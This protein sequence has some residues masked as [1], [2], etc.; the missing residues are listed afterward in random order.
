MSAC[1]QAAAC[2]EGVA[3]T[4][5]RRR[6]QGTGRRQRLCVRQRCP[7]ATSAAAEAATT[8][9]TM[10]K[11]TS[12]NGDTRADGIDAQRVKKPRR[13]HVSC[14]HLLNRFECLL[15]LKCGR[16]VARCFR[17][18]ACGCSVGSLATIVLPLQSL[19]SPRRR[20]RRR[21]IATAP[22]VALGLP[23]R[24]RRA[25]TRCCQFHSQSQQP[26]TDTRQRG[27]RAAQHQT[28]W[29]CEGRHCSP[30][31]GDLCLQLGVQVLRPFLRCREQE[32]G[33]GGCSYDKRSTR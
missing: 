25:P 28:L 6:W 8:S 11:V 22:C 14:P 29:L 5:G 18:A 12:T 7:H 33:E 21:A 15:R 17:M 20:R 9:A 2:G 27:W 1:E 23:R 31:L 24:L 26:H 32:H 10:M 19:L 3:G 30:H 4:T 13:R 16:V